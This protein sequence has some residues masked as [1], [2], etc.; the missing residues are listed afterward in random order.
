[1]ANQ[2]LREIKF[3]FFGET[4]QFNFP[5]FYDISAPVSDFQNKI[6]CVN[7][8]GNLAVI[9]ELANNRGLMIDVHFLFNVS[10][11]KRHFFSKCTFW[12]ST[13]SFPK[14]PEIGRFS[15]QNPDF[16]NRCVH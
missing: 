9:I 5:A 12:K 10:L 13:I 14:Y 1:M 8:V 6:D 2:I 7:L 11:Q 4:A 15:Y 3:Y 16:P